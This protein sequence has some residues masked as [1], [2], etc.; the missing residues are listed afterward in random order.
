[1]SELVYQNY[2]TKCQGWT[3]PTNLSPNPSIDYLSSYQS[4]AG[5]NTVV[6][7]NGTTFYSYSS[8]RFGTF[9]PTT[10]FINSNTIQFYVPNTLTSGTYPVQVFNGSFPSNTVNY[11]IDNASGYWILDANGRISNTNSGGINVSWLSRGAPLILD[12]SITSTVTE[13]YELSNNVTWVI[14][15]NNAINPVYIKLPAGNN[16]IGREITI[17][18][19]YFQNIYASNGIE[20]TKI[21]V[22]LS[23]TTP[24]DIIVPGNSLNGYTIL[25]NGVFWT[26]MV[27]DGSNWQVMQA[28]WG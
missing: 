16:F 23:T 13:P 2:N 8:I 17:K 26:T 4:P 14:C 10:Y 19:L 25:N 12:D 21:I 20:T 15:K 27:Y 3:N 11:T 18:A 9:S 7:I 24:Q 1:M 22:P 28:N 5:S 6:S